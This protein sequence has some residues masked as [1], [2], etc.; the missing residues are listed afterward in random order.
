MN[1]IAANFKTKAD[2]E[3]TFPADL[4]TT[5]EAMKLAGVTSSEW[6]F[7]KKYRPEDFPLQH[8]KGFYRFPHYSASE[9]TA[10]FSRFLK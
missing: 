5:A 4:I 8:G 7:A 9:V 1:I 3:S 6:C 10:F 2:I